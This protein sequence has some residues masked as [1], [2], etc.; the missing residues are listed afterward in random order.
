MNRKVGLDCS[1]PIAITV[2]SAVSA[3]CLAFPFYHHPLSDD[4]EGEALEVSFGLP[5]QLVSTVVAAPAEAKGAA[6][7][8]ASLTKPQIICMSSSVLLSP[9]RAE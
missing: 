7:S 6:L 5:D 4:D 9:L 8:T 3:S 1:A 2:S